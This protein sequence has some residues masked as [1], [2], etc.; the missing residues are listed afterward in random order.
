[1]YSKYNYIF[2]FIF[3]FACQPIE[4][5]NPIVFDNSKLDKI[6][7]NAKQIILNNKYNSIFSDENIEDQLKHPPLKL[8]ESWILENIN[9][10]GNQNTFIINIL[11]A[12]I[13]K[14]EI[15]NEDATKYEEKTIFL[16]EVYFLV[17]YELYDDSE[18]LLA[19]TT[20]ETNRSTTSKKYISLN[21]SELIIN[22]LLNKVLKDFIMESKKMTNNYMSEY[23]Q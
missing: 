10:F 22:D 20:V 14:T 6:S 12:S 17:E 8:L 15:E 7:I 11:D 16:Y 3:L 1:M 21:E 19:N 23:I 2:I 5:I 18:F 4:S 9:H 13:V